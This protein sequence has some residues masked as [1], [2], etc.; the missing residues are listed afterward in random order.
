MTG[1]QELV[2]RNIWRMIRDE[3]AYYDEEQDSEDGAED[4]HLGLDGDRIG[5]VET[6]GPQVTF[7]D[8]TAPSLIVTALGSRRRYRVTVTPEE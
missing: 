8:P 5:A 2:A 1:K 4:A 7:L 6:D 3:L